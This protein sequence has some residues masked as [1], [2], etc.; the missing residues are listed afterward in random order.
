MHVKEQDEKKQLFI[1][2]NIS[3]R[4]GFPLLLTSQHLYS[5]I[6]PVITT[7][8]KGLVAEYTV[9]THTVLQILSY[10]LLYKKEFPVFAELVDMLFQV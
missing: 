6:C 10:W 2:F 7:Q 3:Q 4:R 9:Q 1:S 5:K 8:T